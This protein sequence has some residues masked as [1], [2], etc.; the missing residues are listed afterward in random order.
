MARQVQCV[1]KQPRHDPFDRIKNISGV[2]NGAR[3]KRT[4]PD[5]IQD[6]LRDPTSYY[7]MDRNVNTSVWVIVRTSQQGNK[8]LTTEADGESQ[9]NLLS[10]EE[11]P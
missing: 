4:Q 1:N 11:C 3:W 5:A 7:V 8:Y 6:V 9:N 2:D 10:L